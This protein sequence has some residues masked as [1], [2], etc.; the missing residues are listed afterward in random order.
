M[1]HSG[2]TGLRRDG[3]GTYV[4]AGDGNKQGLHSQAFMCV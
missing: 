2:G 3:S 1:A 4:D